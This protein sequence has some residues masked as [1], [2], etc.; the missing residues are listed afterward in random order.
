MHVAAG[1]QPP[2]NASAFVVGPRDGAGSALQEFARAVGF[3]P[4]E[5]YQGLHR[6]ERRLEETPLVF[7]LCAAVAD[8]GSLKPIADAIRFSASFKLRFA[9]LIYFSRGVSL[10][11]IKRC[12]GMG[13]DDIIALPF[14]AGDLRERLMRQIDKTQV[15]YETATYFGPDRRN[16]IGEQRS[17]ESDHGGGQHRRIELRRDVERGVEVLRDD[18]Q[19]VV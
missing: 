17:S 18:L 7:F 19:V 14:S 1:E 4:V 3:S 8:V 2:V 15:Y 12:I 5:R 16:R 9:P 13:F 11:D 6:A 10:P